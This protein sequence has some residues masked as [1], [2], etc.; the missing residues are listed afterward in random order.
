MTYDGYDRNPQITQN[1]LGLTASRVPGTKLGM[2]TLQNDA[3]LHSN[4]QGFTLVHNENFKQRKCCY[5]R[6]YKM[7]FPIKRLEHFLSKGEDGGR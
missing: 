1:R 4:Q 5:L 3:S 2:E 7:G 6:Y